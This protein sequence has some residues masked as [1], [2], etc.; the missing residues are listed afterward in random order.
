M[1]K[2]LSTDIDDTDFYD[3][4]KLDKRKFYQ[5]FWERIK[6]KLYVLNIILVNEPL[7]P[8]SI[9]TLLFLTKIN[10]YFLI[11]GL[12]INEDFISEIYHSKE[13]WSCWYLIKKSND[14]LFYITFIGVFS[15]YLYTCFLFEEKKI[16]NIFK[17][18][19]DD[20]I[21][22]KNEI[23]L[24]I[25]NIAFGSYPPGNREHKSIT[26][27][28]VND[29]VLPTVTELVASQVFAFSTPVG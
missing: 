12:F 23:Y 21:S 14:N 15:G 6:M 27:C 26:F 11:N 13:E 28:L 8:R 1:K 20:Q 3:A 25:K 22:I 17:R 18:N 24:L 2:Y 16:K 4:M 29:A 5:Y 19:K 9:K 7:I 10:L